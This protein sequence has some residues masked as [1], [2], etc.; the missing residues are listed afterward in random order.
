MDY[1]E[2]HKGA[3]SCRYLKIPFRHFFIVSIAVIHSDFE[4]SFVIAEIMKFEDLKKHGSEAAVKNAG[5]YLSK[6]KDYEVEDGD[7]I[8]II[9]EYFFPLT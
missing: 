7:I 2:T 1:Q 6:G 9:L 3:S 4:K 8:C 5:K